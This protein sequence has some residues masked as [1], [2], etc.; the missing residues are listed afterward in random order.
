MRLATDTSH[1]LPAR[2]WARR[3]R[4]RAIG[5]PGM[6]SLARRNPKSKQAL[7]IVYPPCALCDSDARC[8]H[9]TA[10]PECARAPLCCL[11]WASPPWARA[12]SPH[13]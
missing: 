3:V 4:A 2:E 1:A 6:P 10:T 8:N 7:P 13:P 12:S 11:C 9:V 5:V